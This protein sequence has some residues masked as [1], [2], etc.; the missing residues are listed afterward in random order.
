MSETCSH[1]QKKIDAGLIGQISGHSL[2]DAG[3]NPPRPGYPKKNI[4]R[5]FGGA[6][7]C[8]LE[9][10][11]HD[12]P[13]HGGG[14][15]VLTPPSVVGAAAGKVERLQAG[16]LITNINGIQVQNMQELTKVLRKLHPGDTVR[17]HVERGERHIDIDQPLVTPNRSKLGVDVEQ[18]TTFFSTR[19]G[20]NITFVEKG[21][22]AKAANLEEGDAITNINGAEVKNPADLKRNLD[23]IAPGTQIRLHVVKRNGESVDVYLVTEAQLSEKRSATGNI[24]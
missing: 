12:G 3:K 11:A 17:I 18:W 23:N 5:N 6:L 16:D 19:N 1:T 20:A 14:V 15:R 2:G 7:P 13:N 4:A 24:I 9:D 22:P 8:A 21:S 10:D